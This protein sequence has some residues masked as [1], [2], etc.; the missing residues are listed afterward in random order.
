MIYGTYRKDEVNTYLVRRRTRFLLL[1]LV[2][3]ARRLL[4]VC[5]CRGLESAH[6]FPV[7]LLLA[8][9]VDAGVDLVDTCVPLTQLLDVLFSEITGEIGDKGGQAGAQ[10]VAGQFAG[11]RWEILVSSPKNPSDGVHPKQFS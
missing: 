8:H 2:A 11:A 10:A 9:A 5:R 4:A 6:N 3:L 1:L 7:G